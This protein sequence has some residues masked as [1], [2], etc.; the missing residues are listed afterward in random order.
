MDP[1]RRIP[2]DQIGRERA[3]PS[4]RDG[5]PRGHPESHGVSYRPLTREEVDLLRRNGNVARSWDDLRVAEGFNADQVRSSRFYGR[6]RIGALRPLALDLDGLE[7][8]VGIYNSTVASCEV[9]SDVAIHDVRYLAHYSVEDGAI[10]FDV[11][12]MLATPHP[13]FG[14][15][16]PAGGESGGAREW[17]EV[18]NEAGGRRILPF[19][20]M[21]ASD[22]WLWARN[23]GNPRLLERFEEFTDSPS[24]YADG[25]QASVGE[26]AAIAHCRVV[27]DA[28]IGPHARIRGAERLENLTIRSLPDH[29]VEIGEGVQLAH[30]IVGPGCR[31]R[32]ASQAHHFVLDAYS[33]LSDGARVSHTFLGANSNIRCCEVLHCLIGPN[34]EQ[35]H[36]NSFLIASC[37]EGQSNVAAGA[38][39]GSNHN[40]RAADGEIVARRGFWPGLCTSL[41]HNSRFGS[42][43]LI[44]KG[45]YPAELDVPLPF[46]LVSND[47]SAG[48]L[49]IVPAYWFLYNMFAVARNAHKFRTRAQTG[50]DGL[51]IEFDCV[52]PDTVEEMFSGIDLLETWTG[53]AWFREMNP[54]RVDVPERELREKGR[55]LLSKFPEEVARIEVLAPAC[56]RSKRK[57]RVLKADRA[58]AAYRD[59]VVHYAVRVLGEFER[60]RFPG[61]WEETKA[62][63]TGEALREWTNL[64]GQLVSRGD[65]RISIEKIVAG[66]IDSWEAV[67]QEMDRLWERYPLD[68]AR[69]ALDALIRVEGL[70]RETLTTEKWVGCL[71][72]ANAIQARI[73]GLA[74]ESRARD[75]TDP[76]R[77]MAY[78]STEEMEAVLGRIDEDEC[79][80]QIERE[81]RAFERLADE[82]RRR[83]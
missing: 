69:H 49:R 27:R 34:H 48:C 10:L 24:R 74:R 37:L 73:A 65:L 54:S 39:I 17:I 32:S 5:G 71:D 81:T 53:E 75:Y 12:E 51:R 82:L 59:M 58:W 46:S 31:V 83:G 55:N 19:D 25:A 18:W 57:V 42:F 11:G 60:D 20:G 68:R 26:G 13:R 67:H 6:V 29:P 44:A 64:G 72:R 9:G 56:E 4:R 66:E 45:S 36:N 3:R 47:E 7:L 30:G 35:H 52:A 33:T 2:L 43:T 61:G 23:R 76:F 22:A 14:N 50:P 78:E 62:A 21:R 28:L 80:L 63:L 38:T 1:I 8:A 40:S 70:S 79:I 41:K 77:K 15:G 16:L